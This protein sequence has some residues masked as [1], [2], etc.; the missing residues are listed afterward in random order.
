M[1]TAPPS[2]TSIARIGVSGA[3]ANRTRSEQVSSA[4]GSIG[5]RGVGGRRRNPGPAPCDLHGGP[6]G[7]D[8]GA[9][10]TRAAP[11]A[12]APAPDHHSDR[13]RGGDRCRGSHQRR[14]AA[15]RRRHRRLF[16][17]DDVRPRPEDVQRDRRLGVVRREG[18]PAHSLR[19]GAL[20]GR[21]AADRPQGHRRSRMG[22]CRV[23]RGY[24]RHRPARS[25][26]SS[27]T[28]R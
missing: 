20:D 28:P 25:T 7:S 22:Q 10:R 24:S 8:A 1:G 3:G 27:R 26:T 19:C 15:S 23:P 17:T 11:P 2:Q 18:H 13:R 12:A 14:P 9:R 5:G 6:L 21:A 4:D 16:R